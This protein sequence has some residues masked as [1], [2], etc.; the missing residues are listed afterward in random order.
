MTFGGGLLGGSAGAIDRT[1]DPARDVLEGWEELGRERDE[2]ERARRG[3]EERGVY[4]H[5]NC[6]A[7]GGVPWAV[8]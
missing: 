5:G 1:L 8:P 6:D 2:F 7:W 3:Y 4:G